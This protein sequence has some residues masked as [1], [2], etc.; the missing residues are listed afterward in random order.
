MLRFFVRHSLPSYFCRVSKNDRKE[1]LKCVLIEN[2][3][4]YRTIWMCFPFLISVLWSFIFGYFTSFFIF[5]CQI[6]A[7][8]G[9][10]WFFPLRFG[11]LFQV[12]CIWSRHFFVYDF[13]YLSVQGAWKKKPAFWWRSHCSGIR[14]ILWWF[15]TRLF[16]DLN[17]LSRTKTK[18]IVLH[19][20]GQSGQT[21]S[22]RCSSTCKQSPESKKELRHTVRFYSPD[23]VYI[24]PI[25][26]VS[27]DSIH[28]MN[29]NTHTQY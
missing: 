23:F 16:C 3:L 8:S 1:A 9:L 7:R 12:T 19:A 28:G 13:Q 10:L 15:F 14:R 4:L 26:V 24:S 21:L 20:L 5:T 29:R 18:A 6:S 25:H 11:P 27:S 2:W 17:G 22:S